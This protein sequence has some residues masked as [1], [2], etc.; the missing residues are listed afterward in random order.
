MGSFQLECFGQGL[1]VVVAYQSN[2]SAF[3]EIWRFLS[4]KSLANNR[5]VIKVKFGQISNRKKL[6]ELCKK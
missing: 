3:T 5:H 4:F 1:F 2:E 6:I